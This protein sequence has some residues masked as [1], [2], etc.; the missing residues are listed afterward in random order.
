[1]H[2]D[3]LVSF[4]T[5]A[6]V[7][8]HILNTQQVIGSRR[9]SVAFVRMNGVPF[10]SRILL[11]VVERVTITVQLSLASF[12]L[13]FACAETLTSTQVL[14]GRHTLDLVGLMRGEYSIPTTDAVTISRVSMLESTFFQTSS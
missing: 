3:L 4:T 14:K 2:T 11:L 6:S 12:G 7:A 10:I 5:E 1:M 9:V 13:Q 8:A